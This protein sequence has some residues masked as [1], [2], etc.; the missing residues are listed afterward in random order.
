MVITGINV[1]K[2]GLDLNEN[3]TIYTLL[4]ALCRDFPEM[5]IRLS[6]IE[7]TEVTGQL[8]DIM[9]RYENFMPHLHIPLQSGDDHILAR[10]NRRYTAEVFVRTIERIV[11]RFPHAAIGCDVL[12]GFPGEDDAAAENT[13]RLLSGLP[14]SYLHV[15]P[16]SKRPGTLAAS[17]PDQI[18]GR[19]K[20]GRVGRLRELDTRKRLEF[21][22]RHVCASHWVL[23]ERRSR[24]SSLLQGFSE[25]Y[26][27]IQFDGPDRLIRQVVRV[28]IK[29]IQDGQPIAVL[30]ESK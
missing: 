8:L 6:S 13:F 3:Q 25:N 22:Q 1:G 27:P 26:I 14:I 18:H 17:F 30:E 16:Y 12:A 20:D 11:S 5:R 7:P 23:V 9:A 15:F 28:R 24:K 10:M 4:E 21:Y 2:Y 19:I 29:K